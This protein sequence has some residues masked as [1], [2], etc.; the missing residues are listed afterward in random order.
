MGGQAE[1]H[2]DEQEYT[3]RGEIAII[4]LDGYAILITM[5]WMAQLVNNSWMKDDEL[6]CSIDLRLS[7]ASDIGNGR[8]LFTVSQMNEKVIFYPSGEGCIDPATV[9]GL[10]LASA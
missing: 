1:V 3:F 8:I 9:Q 10:E 4:E 6:E 5:K 2:N 7:R